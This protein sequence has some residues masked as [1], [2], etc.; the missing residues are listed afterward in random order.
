MQC[1]NCGSENPSDRKFCGE[2]GAHL[3]LRCPKCGTENFPPFRFCGECGAALADLVIG[4]AQE[5]KLISAITGE[6]RRLTVLFCD[7][8]GSTEIASRLDPEE[9]RECSLPHHSVS[10]SSGI[11]SSDTEVPLCPTQQQLRVA[12]VL[13]NRLRLATL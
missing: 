8:V 10:F 9:W 4:R 13:A 3:L 1:S 5:T 6:R 11:E 2:C 12:L 7:L